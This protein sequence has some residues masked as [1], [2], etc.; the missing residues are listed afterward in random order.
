MTAPYDSSE[1]SLSLPVADPLLLMTLAN[2]ANIT[3]HF[4]GDTS[5]TDTRFSRYSVQHLTPGVISLTTQLS[6]KP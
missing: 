3:L 1:A 2:V 5:M 6:P 4:C